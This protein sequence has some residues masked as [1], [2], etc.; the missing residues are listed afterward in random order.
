MVS[1]HPTVLL[2]SV[3]I[4]FCLVSSSR[5]FSTKNVP[6]LQSAVVL[7][8]S[9]NDN[10]TKQ[11]DMN[12]LTKSSWYGV[13]LFGKVF[14]SAKKDAEPK[15][16]DYSG[17]LKSLDETFA[18]IKLDNDRSYFLSGQVDEDIYDPECVFSDPFVSFTGRDRFVENLANLGSFITN[19][20]A[21][22]LDYDADDSTMVQT[23]IMVKLELNLP[24]KPVLAWPWGVKY[25]IDPETCLI[26]D[27]EESW[28]IDAW[29][30]IAT[31]VDK[32]FAVSSRGIR[33]S[34]IC[35]AADQQL[36]IQEHIVFPYICFW[37]S[38]QE[39]ERAE[40]D[41]KY[42]WSLLRF[43]K[44]SIIAEWEN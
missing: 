17:S 43:M 29:E 40:T 39:H 19:Y 31:L 22:V 33:E 4:S 44:A 1:S 34:K 41:H 3:V 23:K 12:P 14:G 32:L 15:E 20:S 42:P 37:Q 13:E 5:G 24:W 11:K 26:V 7:S 25:T 9:A 16:E 21:K 18:R 27:H 38:Y 2:L 6:R 28:D 8:N 35:W 36:I 30:G 10:D